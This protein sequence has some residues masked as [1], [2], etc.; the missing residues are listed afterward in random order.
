MLSVAALV[1][2]SSMLVGQ[3]EGEKAFKSQ[4][5]FAVGGTW[6]TTVDG[7]EF[8]STY[9][10]ILDGQFM[11]LTNKAAGGF[12]A[13]VSILGVDPVTKKFTQWGF[14]ADGLVSIGTTTLAADGTWVGEWHGKGPKGTV[15]SKF[16]LTRVDADT[17]KYEVLEQKLEGDLKPFAKVT[18]WKR[19]R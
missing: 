4:A 17:A 6:I 2:A 1:M 13:A 8:E 18:I 9:E 19:H 15:T 5:D 12:P 10:R 3:A 7:Q 16:R 11:R 14:D